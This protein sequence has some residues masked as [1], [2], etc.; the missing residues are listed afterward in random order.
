MNSYGDLFL[1]INEYDEERM[2]YVKPRQF[3]TVVKSVGV[4]YVKPI[5]ETEEANEKEPIT[6][7]DKKES[8][9]SKT[10]SKKDADKVSKEETVKLVPEVVSPKKQKIIVNT[11]KMLIPFGIKEFDNNGKKSYQMGLSFSTMTNLYNEES[12]KKFCDFIEKVDAANSET[13]NSQKSRWKLPSKMK[14]QKTVKQFKENFPDFMNITLPY[15]EEQGILTKIYDEKAKEASIDILKKK[16]IVSV[17]LELTDLKF[18]DNRFRSNWV[19]LQIRKFLPISPIQEFFRNGCVIRDEDNPEDSVYAQM[20]EKYQKHLRIPLNFPMFPQ[21]N[22]MLLQAVKMH[23]PMGYPQHTFQ[24]PMNMLEYSH[25]PNTHNDRPIPKPPERPM[26]TNTSCFQP[27]TLQELLDAKKVLKKTV[28]VVKG[29]S[30]NGHVVEDKPDKVDD[31][32]TPPPVPSMNKKKS[33]S[34]NKSRKKTIDPPTPP[35]LLNNPKKPKK[36][37]VSRKED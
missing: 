2:R 21:M 36:R 27:P 31:P 1:D 10:K 20:I 12:I 22:P 14:Y 3:Y 4:Y 26:E 25:P 32:P 7:T 29:V 18:S 30:G 37:R 5:K 19:A 9:S 11:P 33:T 15:D 35:K 17:A 34:A 13:V 24:P 16:S 28:T 23:M 6:K 8:T